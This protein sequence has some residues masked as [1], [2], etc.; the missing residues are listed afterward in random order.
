MLS[1][2]SLLLLLNSL[3]LAFALTATDYLKLCLALFGI[4]YC[5]VLGKM[6]IASSGFCFFMA[7]FVFFR[8]ML[9]MKLDSGSKKRMGISGSKK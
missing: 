1:G 4:L 7:A 8:G 3:L 2:Y 6:L 9:A 5:C